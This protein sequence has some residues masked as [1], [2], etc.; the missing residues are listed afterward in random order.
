MPPVLPP[1]VHAYVH[2]YA[3]T[4][5]WLCLPMGGVPMGV[6]WHRYRGLPMECLLKGT[7]MGWSKG[8]LNEWCVLKGMK[9]MCRATIE[10]GNKPGQTRT[11]PPGGGKK[12]KSDGWPGTV[13]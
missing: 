2:A 7:A 6:L 1:H 13:S 11:Y 3:C 8:M 9:G 12:V 5:V 4:Y 10:H